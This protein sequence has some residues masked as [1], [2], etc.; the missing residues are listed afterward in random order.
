MKE[1][2][3]RNTRSES[4]TKRKR[5]SLFAVWSLRGLSPVVLQIR[6]TLIFKINTI[7]FRD[8]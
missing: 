6:S 7:T 2:A 5:S 3:G 4:E 8:W 1:A